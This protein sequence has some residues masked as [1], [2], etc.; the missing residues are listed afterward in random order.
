MLGQTISHYQIIEKLGE[1][2]MG[3]VYKVR[4]SPT[5]ASKRVGAIFRIPPSPSLSR[6]GGTQE[7]WQ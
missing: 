7:S 4:K 6:G 5:S 3:I 1:G 2:G